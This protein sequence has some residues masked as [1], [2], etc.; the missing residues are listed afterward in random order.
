MPCW[1]AVT[2]RRWPDGFA[3]ADVTEQD[4]VLCLV[5]EVQADQLL[6]PVVVGKADRGPVVPIEGLAGGQVRGF[7]EPPSA[8]VL[9]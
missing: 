2:A 8:G 5:E 9:P 1:Q 3:G 6:A 7:E 4:Q